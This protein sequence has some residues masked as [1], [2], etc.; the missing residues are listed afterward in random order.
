MSIPIPGYIHL[1]GHNAAL[2]LEGVAA[3]FHLRGEFN[4]FF[5]QATQYWAVGMAK[6]PTLTGIII[7]LDYNASRYESP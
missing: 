3:F 5:E 6:S 4:L 2:H 1:E 7:K